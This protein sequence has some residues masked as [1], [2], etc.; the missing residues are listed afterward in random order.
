MCDLIQNEIRQKINLYSQDE[1]QRLVDKRII[2]NLEK[3]IHF[4]KTEIETKNKI[5]KNFI[6]KDP[7]RDENNNVPQGWANSGVYT[8]IK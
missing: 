4:L 5:I 6:K 3:E 1:H 2:A 7:H 8:H